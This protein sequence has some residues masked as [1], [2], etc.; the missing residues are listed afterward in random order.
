M[1]VEH[2]ACCLLLVL[3]ALLSIICPRPS[4]YLIIVSVAPPVSPSLPSFVSLYSL[5]VSAVLFW[6]FVLHHVYVD[7]TAVPCPPRPPPW[8][9]FCS[10]CFILLLKTRILLHLN[11]RLISLITHPASSDQSDLNVN[12]VITTCQLVSTNVPG[13][14]ERSIYHPNSQWGEFEWAK[15][16]KITAGEFQRLVEFWTQ[17]TQAINENHIKITTHYL[18]KS[19]AVILKQTPAY[20]VV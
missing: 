9:G 11:P 12:I 4:C 14:L 6:S 20:S 18:G 10:P 1:Y 17:K 5:L 15:T 19:S 13:G 8:G 7:C 2:M 16:Q 3:C